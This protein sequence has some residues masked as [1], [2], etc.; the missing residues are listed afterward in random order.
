ML[1]EIDPESA[2]NIHP[3]KYGESL[4]LLK[5]LNAQVKLQPNT[6]NNKCQ[7]VI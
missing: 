6:I 3:N 4:E 7:S 1:K 2:S 5:Y